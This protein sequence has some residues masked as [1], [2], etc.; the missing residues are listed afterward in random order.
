MDAKQWAGMAASLVQRTRPFVE[1]LSGNEY[2][3]CAGRCTTV[4]W[5]AIQMT[6]L[7]VR[8]DPFVKQLVAKLPGQSAA[9]F[10]DEQFLALKTALGGRTWGGGACD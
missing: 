1:A 10:S 7:A 6:V 2:A 4:D 5:K 9:T 3:I 8:D